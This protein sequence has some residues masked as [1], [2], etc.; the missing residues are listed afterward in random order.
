M[1]SSPDPTPDGLPLR[2][3]AISI[4]CADAGE[5]ADFYAE[6]LGM[7]RIYSRPDGD[8]VAISDGTHTLAMMHIDDYVPPT[9]PEADRPQQMHFDI[10]VTDLDA[11]TAKALSV[12]ARLAEHQPAPAEWRV[13]LDPAGHPFCLTTYGA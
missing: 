3:G 10:S 1:T 12:G 11:A 8:I 13:F 9:W 4:D 2:I 6:L 7:Q 5:L